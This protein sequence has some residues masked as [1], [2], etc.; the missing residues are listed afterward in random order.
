MR[1]IHHLSA[2]YDRLCE[3]FR[4]LY[5]NVHNSPGTILAKGETLN[6]MFL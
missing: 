4:I 1:N 6:D 3:E 5:N 2:S